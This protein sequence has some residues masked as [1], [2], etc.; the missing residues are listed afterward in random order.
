MKV[1]QTQLLELAKAAGVEDVEVVDDPK[2]SDFDLN[3]ALSAID[4]SRSTVLKPT[5]ENEA[6]AAI[7]SDIAGKSAG[8]LRAAL[9]QTTG[10]DRKLLE[11]LKDNEA[12]KLAM[13]HY[14]KALGA[15]KEEVTRMIEEV[16]SNK[17]KEWKEKLDPLEK[18]R[19]EWKNKY[20]RRDIVQSIQKGLSKAPLPPKLDR[21]LASEDLENYARGK[22]ILGTNPDTGD[23]MFYH[24]DKPNVPAMN[25]S[26]MVTLMDVA[27]EFF[28]PRNNWLTD[29]RTADPVVKTNEQASSNPR[30]LPQFVENTQPPGGNGQA[31]SYQEQLTKAME[32]MVDQQPK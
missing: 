11:G 14:G 19:D 25:G 4:A 10:I 23:V 17:D 27:K 3:N 24:K 29:T 6:T 12:I 30:A 15:S 5:W 7:R 8:I 31:L 9:S 18:E 22:Y 32:Q 28:E 26:Q 2:L 1:T 20:E 21:S 13:E 16:S